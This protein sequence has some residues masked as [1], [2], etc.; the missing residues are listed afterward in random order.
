M[1]AEKE[2]GV[3]RTYR[4]PAA[5]VELI[6]LL[7]EKGILGANPTAVVRALLSAALKDLVEKEYPQKHHAT[8]EFLKKK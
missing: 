2:N 4:L 7:A 3:Q 1:A 8:L 6:E 5:D